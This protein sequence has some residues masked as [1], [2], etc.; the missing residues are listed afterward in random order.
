M[1]IFDHPNK[2]LVDNG[3]ES[4]NIDFQ[5]LC[6]NFNIRICTTAVESPWSNDLIERHNAVLGLTVQLY[7]Q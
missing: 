5:K 6:V 1:G 2:I 7:V 4:D 3:G